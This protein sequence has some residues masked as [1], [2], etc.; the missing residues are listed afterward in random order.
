[1]LK[2][3]SFDRP[4]SNRSQLTFRASMVLIARHK[5]HSAR[6]SRQAARP[7]SIEVLHVPGNAVATV[8]DAHF[9]TVIALSSLATALAILPFGSAATEFG[10]PVKHASSAAA[11][12]APAFS[13]FFLQMTYCFHF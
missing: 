1:M 8:S 9:L 2:H 7:A 13:V 6:A 3:D 5:R 12:I 4:S 11:A 10:S